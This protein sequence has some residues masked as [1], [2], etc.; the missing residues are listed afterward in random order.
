[1][2]EN[3]SLRLPSRSAPSSGSE[4][5]RRKNYR[6]RVLKRARV[7]LSAMTC[8]DCEIRDVAEGGARIEFAGPVALPERFQLLTV[9]TRRLVPVARVWQRGLAAG[10]RFTGV[11]EKADLR[12][13]FSYSI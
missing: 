7:V 13:L 3:T 2:S 11:M 8:I 6:V 12:K 4:D 1:M 5:S 10:V 9:S